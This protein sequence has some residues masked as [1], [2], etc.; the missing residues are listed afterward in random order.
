MSQEWIKLIGI[1]LI[2]NNSKRLRNDKMDNK[3]KRILDSRPL[4]LSAE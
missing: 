3:N 4:V 1:L 2:I